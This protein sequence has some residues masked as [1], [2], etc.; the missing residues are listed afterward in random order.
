MFATIEPAGITL[1]A[2]GG[3]TE[4]GRIS[5]EL[6]IDWPTTIEDAV[7]PVDSTGKVN[8]RIVRLAGAKGAM[9]L[10]GSLRADALWGPSWSLIRSA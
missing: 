6:K 7:F 9:E 4:L 8:V 1:V 3:A 10:N 2:T 5:Q